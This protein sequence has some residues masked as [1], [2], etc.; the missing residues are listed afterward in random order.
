[1]DVTEQLELA[2]VVP[3]QDKAWLE[4]NWLHGASVSAGK[5]AGLAD[6]LVEVA[7]YL[8]LA[9]VTL[10]LA[11]SH[12]DL[13]LSAVELEEPELQ[14]AALACLGLAAKV[15]EDFV[16]GPALLLSLTSPVATKP[17]LAQAE[18]TVLAALQFRLRRTTAASFL[19]Y[20]TQLLPREARPIG[21]LARAVLDLALLAPW[22][23][24]VRPSHLAAA[25][26]TLA[27]CLLQVPTLQGLDL[28]LSLAASLLQVPALL[29]RDLHLCRVLPSCTTLLYRLLAL[30]EARHQMPGVEAKHS[31][32][33][34]RLPPGSLARVRAE[35]EDL[36]EGQSRRDG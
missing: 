8:Q 29:S 17:A 26:L 25:V 30:L 2:L 3:G 31:K 5:R 23:G 32:V 4:P 35:L 9:D 18:R 11:V 16:P 14:L 33:L 13:L 7:A 21:R 10:H 28:P 6:W 36:L 34:G 22:H 15:E 24:Q 12:L 19:H 1:M 27:N 20:Y